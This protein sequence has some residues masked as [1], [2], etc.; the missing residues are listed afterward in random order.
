MK[1]QTGNVAAWCKEDNLR[2]Y[3]AVISSGSALYWTAK[4]E[5]AQSIIKEASEI[6]LKP[7]E[8]PGLFP[9]SKIKP[10]LQTHGRRFWRRHGMQ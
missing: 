9:V 3:T 4:C 2:G 7:K 6:S 1:K 8:M 10:K 5:M